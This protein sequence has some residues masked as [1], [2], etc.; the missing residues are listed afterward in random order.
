MSD[1]AYGG[2]A[3]LTRYQVVNGEARHTELIE[4]DLAAVLR[5]D[6]AAN[7]Q[8]EPFDTLSIK[9]VQAWTDQESITLRGRGQVPR[10]ATP[11]SRGR[12][13]SRCYCAPAA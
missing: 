12:R 11:S 9:Q 3:E 4:V 13:S 5:G 2:T 7:L 10:H 8:L 1:S 6:P